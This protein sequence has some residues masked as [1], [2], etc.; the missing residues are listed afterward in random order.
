MMRISYL[1]DLNVL[2]MDSLM[3]WYF[4]PQ[5]A[6]QQLSAS[7]DHE[8]VSALTVLSELRNPV[9]QANLPNN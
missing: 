2:A 5:P 8:N 6:H 7:F 3:K 9:C 4:F 1:G